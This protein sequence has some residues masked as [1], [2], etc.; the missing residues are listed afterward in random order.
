MYTYM[1]TQWGCVMPN[2]TIYVSDADLPLYQRAQELAGGNL[3]GVIS[4]ALRQYVERAEA[5]DAGFDE[6]TLQVGGAVR[7]QVRFI[8]TLLGELGRIHGGRLETIAVYR[9]RSGRFVVHRDRAPQRG[10]WSPGGWRGYL[11]LG[12]QSWTFVEGGSTVEVVETL[13]ELRER[14]PADFYEMIAGAIDQPAL[15]Y[16]DV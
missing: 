7:R 2:K 4:A 15:E 10:A 16:L 14:L 1:W 11:G 6:V 5:R 9:G 8:G 13:D 3:S 12:D